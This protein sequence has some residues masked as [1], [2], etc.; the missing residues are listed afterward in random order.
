[1]L[2]GLS[3]PDPRYCGKPCIVLV[4]AKDPAD[5]FA[6]VAQQLKQ[7]AGT[8]RANV[9]AIGLGRQ[10]SDSTLCALATIPLRILDPTI[11]DCVACFEW[12]VQVADSVL[13]ALS[14]ASGQA[15][16]LPPLPKGV[17]WLR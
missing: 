15:V 11:Q 17:Q 1:L 12:L 2:T 6:S 7:L 10:V 14:Q 9:T 16:T 8:G 3:A 13:R 5:D 4:L